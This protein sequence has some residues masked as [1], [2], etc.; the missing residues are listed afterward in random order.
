MHFNSRH[1]LRVQI[2]VEVTCPEASR[3]VAVRNSVSLNANMEHMKRL[4]DINH[5]T[6]HEITELGR[7]SRQD[8]ISM[9]YLA[10][11][12]MIFLPLTA[13]SVG[14]KSKRSELKSRLTKPRLFQHG[15]LQHRHFQFR[16]IAFPVTQIYLV[17]WHCSSWSLATYLFS[18]VAQVLP[19]IA[20]TTSYDN[21]QGRH[22]AG[23]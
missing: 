10:E 22:R 23:Q 13:V 19:I 21:R 14:S 3:V 20:D 7:L 9:K 17:V 15:L 1:Y 12:I 16:Y 6:S 4:A 2:T 8:A 5:E 18:L 11:I